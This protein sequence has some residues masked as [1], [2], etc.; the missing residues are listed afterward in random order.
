MQLVCNYK[1]VQLGVNPRRTNIKSIGLKDYYPVYI[2]ESINSESK[3][4][5][6]FT[7]F[8]VSGNNGIENVF[9]E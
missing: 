9:Y 3:D 8:H 5:K 6:K 4:R 1:R 2:L 7:V